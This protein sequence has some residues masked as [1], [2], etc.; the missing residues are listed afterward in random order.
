MSVEEP[1]PPTVN[2]VLEGDGLRLSWEVKN[3]PGCLPVATW[4]VIRQWEDAEGQTQEEDYGRLDVTSVAVPA[5]TAGDHTFL[6]R[7]IDSG[8]N[9]GPWGYVDF[10]AQAPGRVTF[11]QPTV[12]DNNV[13]LYW[14]PP[15]R[16]FF[17]IKEYIFSEIDEDGY[18][19]EIGRVDALFASE[20][21]SESGMFTYGITPV[22]TGGNTGQRTTITCRVAQPPDFVFYDKVDS[23]FNG[24]KTNLVLDGQGHMLGPVPSAETWEENAER[25]IEEASLSATTAS[26]TH[27]Q[28]VNAG[29]KTWLEPRAAK[30]MYVEAIDHGSLIPNSNITVTL[31]YEVLRG[32][33][34][35]TCKIET[36]QD[37]KQ[38][39]IASDN[40]FS[41]YVSQFRYTRIT[42]TITGGYVQINS[43][44]VDLNVKQITDGGRVE[45]KATENGEGFV[46]ETSTPMLTGTWV[47]FTRSFV[48]VQSLPQPNVVNNQGYTAFTVFEDVINPKGFR[49]FVKDKNG[50]RV[51][52]QVD[53]IALGV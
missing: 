36:S 18:E 8:G 6:V 2:S 32:A 41:V 44:L 30:G 28:K 3:G 34:E 31:G 23:L 15:N 19:M 26:L 14:T 13:Q 52:A 4:D 38:W 11:T 29:F 49:I 53:W 46:S 20:T 22:D 10:T 7:A 48:D 37:K 21:E 50:T 47:A 1:L 35:I 45:C 40:A 16:I 12:I 33:P 42:L 43:L 5:V 39:E 9:V 51:T 27:Q 17:P 25:V 24:T